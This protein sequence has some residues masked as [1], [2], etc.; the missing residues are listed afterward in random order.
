[1]L[2]AP[3]KPGDLAYKAE[4]KR[5]LQATLRFLLLHLLCSKCRCTEN[6]PLSASVST[7]RLPQRNIEPAPARA[8]FLL[9]MGWEVFFI[10][11]V[12]KDFFPLA[13]PLSRSLP[14]VADIAKRR[15]ERRRKKSREG[16]EGEKKQE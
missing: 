6:P 14:R 15:E 13:L 4:T 1:M 5:R 8:L 2:K 10:M 12:F 16:R 7:F 9:F 11:I 3:F